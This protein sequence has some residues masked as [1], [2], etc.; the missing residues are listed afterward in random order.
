MNTSFEQA[1]AQSA[2]SKQ[3]DPVACHLCVKHRYLLPHVAI[4]VMKQTTLWLLL[5]FPCYMVFGSESD[6]QI[7]TE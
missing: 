4:L 2:T 6:H 1:H 3:Q 7:L 5:Q